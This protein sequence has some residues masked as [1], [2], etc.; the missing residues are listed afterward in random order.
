LIR[1]LLKLGVIEIEE[2]LKELRLTEGRGTGIPTI[3]RVLSE[4]GSDCAIF[5]TNEPERVYFI[6]EIFMHKAFKDITPEVTPEVV[7]LVLVM[8]G[9]MTRKEIQ[10]K[11]FLSDEKHFR[12]KYQQTAIEFGLIEMTIPDKPKSRNQKYRL[13]EM[14]KTLKNGN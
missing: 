6:I 11:L 3:K 9:E 12:E 8:S 5:D 4:N 2:F 10:N 14:G 13:T 1:G 7:K